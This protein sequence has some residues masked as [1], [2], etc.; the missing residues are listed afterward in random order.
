MNDDRILTKLSELVS[1]P[2][3]TEWCEFKLNFAEPQQIGEYLSAM[4]NSAALQS[5][6]HGYIGWG[7]EDGT[8][9]VVGTRFKPR[10]TKGAGNEDLEP[11]LARML[12]PRVDF[13]IQEFLF[14]GKPIVLFE[15]QA[16]NNSPVAFSG[17]EW[18]RV[19][20]HK[21]PLKDYPERSAI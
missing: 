10:Q 1:L 21:K 20:S 7:I 5:E 4:S 15:V 11:W 17:R 13:K 9:A 19:G 12:S 3:E 6:P 8:R 16:A 14:E 18:I 2:A